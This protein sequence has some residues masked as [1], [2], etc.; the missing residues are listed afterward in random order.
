M[1]RV[2]IVSLL[3]LGA[4]ITC[5]A[6]AQK[7]RVQVANRN[8]AG[9][10]VVARALNFDQPPV[11]ELV[12][13][14]VFEFEGREYAV[15]SGIGNKQFSLRQS[16][17]VS[18]IEAPSADTKVQNEKDLYRI[19]LRRAIKGAG[20]IAVSL[21]YTLQITQHTNAPEVDGEG[22]DTGRR[23]QQQTVLEMS[24][25]ALV[26]PNRRTVLAEL[27]GKPLTVTIEPMVDY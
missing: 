17:T 20:P 24:G 2:A 9:P 10:N 22:G 1:K 25:V 8:A 11:G 13:R 21:E 3:L 14:M 15:L 7:V 19:Y 26:H 18:Q 5:Y 6:V 27:P 16:T 12:C 4:L 23:E